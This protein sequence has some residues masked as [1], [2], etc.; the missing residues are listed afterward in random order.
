MI[1]ESSG[2]VIGATGL[3]TTGAI[4]FFLVPDSLLR[5]V[6]AVEKP[7]PE[8]L[9]LTRHWGF[10]VFLLGLLLVWAVFEPLIRIPIVLAAIV[11]KLAFA[12][13]VWRS[14][15]RVRTLR[16]AAGGDALLAVL[17]IL[18]LMGL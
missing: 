9:L 1:S 7:S 12:V 8:L 4:G 17:L 3:I 15:V 5:L 13:L 11:E 6:F 16:L 2:F 14:P 10:M 18:W